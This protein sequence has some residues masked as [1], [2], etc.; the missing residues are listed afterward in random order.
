MTLKVRNFE[1]V[2]GRIFY[3]R[4][5]SNKFILRKYCTLN[6][7][8]SHDSRIIE[9]NLINGILQ[10]REDFA[11]NRINKNVLFWLK[12]VGTPIKMYKKITVKY[13]IKMSADTEI[14]CVTNYETF[15][16]FFELHL[17][18]KRAKNKYD[19]LNMNDKGSF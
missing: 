2:K 18:F 3:I 10:F 15:L 7:F 8:W 19:L 17:T 4:Y 1:T 12:I 5:W 6:N 11:K 9:Q 13:L 14:L 16:T